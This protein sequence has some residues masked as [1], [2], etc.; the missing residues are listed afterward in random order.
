MPAR[1]CL[2]Q[3]SHFSVTHLLYLL[4]HLHQ[5]NQLRMLNQG[6]ATGWGHEIPEAKPAARSQVRVSDGASEIAPSKELPKCDL[7]PHTTFSGD[8]CRGRQRLIASGGCWGETALHPFWTCPSGTE[9]S[10]PPFCAFLALLVKS[11]IAYF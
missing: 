10:G 4:L 6:A 9:V 2:S 8:R 1:G 3:G 5:E 11:F 7:L